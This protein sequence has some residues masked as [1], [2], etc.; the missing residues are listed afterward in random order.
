[1]VKLVFID[2]ELRGINI[3]APTTLQFGPDGRLYVGEQTGTIK[4]FTVDSLDLGNY[5]AVATE[6]IKLIQQMPNHDDDGS[7]NTS[8]SEC[9]IRQVTGLLVVGTAEQPVIYVTSSDFRA[10]A[11]PL[12]DDTDL[13]TN[14][15][16]VSRLTWNGSSW[17][18]MDIVRGLPRSEENHSING[19][20][21]NE[22]TNTLFL[23]VGGFTNA[24]APSNNFAFTSEFALSACIVSIDLEAINALGSQGTAPNQYLY[25]LPTVDDPERENVNG[26]TDPNDPS[27]DG[28]DI[29]DPFGGNDGL[30]QA[31]LVAGG[32]VQIHSSGWRNPYDVI[33]T[34]A[35]YMFSV[36]NGANNNW[37]G[38]PIGVG[39][40]DSIT[41]EVSEIGFLNNENGLH[42]I[43]QAGYYAGHPNPI[44]ANPDGAGIY[45]FRIEEGGRYDSCVEE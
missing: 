28:I 25:D 10:G 3:S 22:A 12:G 19:M 40:A 15:G 31:R 6:E 44:R 13:D 1:M 2:S 36:D 38:Y 8:C 30:N 29:G 35:G 27:Y 24:G 41:N 16:I 45:T 9:K 32:P 33:I 34:E 42:Y 39:N 7:L 21:L 5:R 14:S 4:I 37:G 23:G 26:I 17:D 11:G 18:K 20:A 43:P